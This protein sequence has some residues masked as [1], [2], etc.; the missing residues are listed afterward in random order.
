M[1]FSEETELLLPNMV[2][3]DRKEVQDFICRDSEI[4]QGIPF[5]EEVEILLRKDQKNPSRKSQKAHLTEKVYNLEDEW[6]LD[7]KNKKLS[8]TKMV[9]ERN[10]LHFSRPEDREVGSKVHKNR[11][12]PLC[13]TGTGWFFCN[14]S[15]EDKQVTEGLGLGI[16]VYFKQVKSLTLLFL[17]FT[18]ISIP[19][20]VLFYFGGSQD[21]NW[22]EPK[23]LFSTFTI[24]NLGESS[25][26]CI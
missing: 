19:A 9:Y 26:Q 18:L 8:Y 12:Y 3:D 6:I 15:K 2:F 1:N 20:Y 11:R 7:T 14:K 25:S 5:C 4:P 10:L 16:S 17:V 21:P 24:G 22:S 23:I 13:K